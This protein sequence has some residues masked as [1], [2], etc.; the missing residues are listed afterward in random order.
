[1][2]RAS[3]PSR[4]SPSSAHV[5]RWP[6]TPPAPKR[7]AST[8]LESAVVARPTMSGP[9]P[10]RWGEPFRPVAI[11]DRVPDQGHDVVRLLQVLVVL[12]YD[13][14][15]RRDAAVAREDKP[16]VDGAA[17]ECPVSQWPTRI[18]CLKSFEVKPVRL[19]ET[20]LAERALRALWRTTKRPSAGDR[21]DV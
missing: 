13:E 14:V 2:E 16:D 7:W 19:L 18:Q 20:R 21:G 1:M 17:L 9:W 4:S 5:S 8:T 11:R 6:P 10:R 12:E 3:F 15:V